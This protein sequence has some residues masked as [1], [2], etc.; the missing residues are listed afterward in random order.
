MCEIIPFGLGDEAILVFDYD[1]TRYDEALI[2]EETGLYFRDGMFYVELEYHGIPVQDMS[3]IQISQ[4]LMPLA[5]N[6]SGR[7]P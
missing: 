1:W 4:F 3:E 2:I 7:I 6:V 5:E